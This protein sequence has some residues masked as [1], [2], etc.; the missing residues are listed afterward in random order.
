MKP[1]S[2]FF[3]IKKIFEKEKY[4]VELCTYS[5]GLNPPPLVCTHKLLS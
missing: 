3:S 1:Q 2:F 5:P 4:T